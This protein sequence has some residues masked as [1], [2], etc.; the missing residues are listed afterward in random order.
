M[1]GYAHAGLGGAAMSNEE[2]QLKETPRRPLWQRLVAL[3]EGK[4]L[5]CGVVVLGGYV[6]CVLLARMRSGDL[7][8]ALWSMTTTHILGGRAAGILWGLE[9]RLSL[10]LVVGANAAIETFLVLLFYPLFVF[11]YER[12]IVIK[13]LEET[14]ARARRAAKAHERTVMEF[15]VPGLL[16]FVWFPF[17]MTGPLIG[18]VIGFL[19]GLRPAVNILAVLGGTYLAILS[20]GVFLHGVHR[21]LAAVSPYVPFAFVAV[22]LLLAVSIH[23]RYAFSRHAEGMD[24]ESDR[25][26]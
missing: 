16:L 9:H 15:G 17:W 11:S 25:R 13:P 1:G 14:M 3:P 8:H 19:I 18:S 2:A 10:W 21:S 7:F 20:W 24:E 23:I 4:I 5:I 6:A 26:G 12:L 22:I